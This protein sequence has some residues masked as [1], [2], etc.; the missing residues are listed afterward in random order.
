MQLLNI[1]VLFCDCLVVARPLQTN[2]FGVFVMP[3]WLENQVLG[4]CVLFLLTSNEVPIHAGM[5]R[6][7]VSQLVTTPSPPALSLSSHVLANACFSCRTCILGEGP[8]GCWGCTSCFYH[9][10]PGR[11]AL[12]YWC[13]SKPD[14]EHLKV[15]TT[16]CWLLQSLAANPC[17]MTFT[18]GMVKQQC[19]VTVC[20]HLSWSRKTW[21]R[22][23]RF[24]LSE[25]GE[26]AA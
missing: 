17:S 13:I 14:Q 24:W 9:N 20:L 5:P 23:W 4:I 26:E 12:A 11:L 7:L 22:L 21:A 25:W 2:W 1:K 16:P 6:F 10:P 3:A 8:P 19:C 18:A 15:E